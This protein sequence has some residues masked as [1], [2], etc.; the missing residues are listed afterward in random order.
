LRSRFG[1]LSPS[2]PRVGTSSLGKLIS[3]YF[4]GS[5]EIPLA[6]IFVFPF[7]LSSAVRATQLYIADE[8]SR[9][10][11]V[12]VYARPR[13]LRLSKG[14]LSA[15]DDSAAGRHALLLRSLFP[16]AEEALLYYA[17]K[18]AAFNFYAVHAYPLIRLS[19]ANESLTS[20][21]PFLFP[22]STSAPPSGP[23]KPRSLSSIISYFPN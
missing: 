17:A 14:S 21:C 10:M 22:G 4:S 1:G 6:F 11:V 5:A 7:L 13:E 2:S 16:G 19:L 3:S 12:T 8:F 20:F 9:Q 18:D 23:G 15:K